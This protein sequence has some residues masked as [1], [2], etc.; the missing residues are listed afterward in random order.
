MRE[1]NQSVQVETKINTN[2]VMA[3]VPIPY[4]GREPFFTIPPA[5]WVYFLPVCIGIG[6]GTVQRHS[7]E[8]A[9]FWFNLLRFLNDIQNT[10]RPMFIVGEKCL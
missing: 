8:P 5:H 7:H 4:L 6:R 3:S 2:S 9:L 10:R 1:K